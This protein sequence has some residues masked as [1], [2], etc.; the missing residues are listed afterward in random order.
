MMESL[1]LFLSDFLMFMPQT[2]TRLIAR[3][4]QDLW[5]WQIIALISGV[6]LLLLIWYRPAHDHLTRLDLPRS[7]LNYDRLNY[8]RLINAGLCVCWLWVGLVFHFEY[9]T[10]ITWVAWGFG[11]LFVLQGGLFLCFGVVL[12]KIQYQHR[13]NRSLIHRSGLVLVLF[14]LFIWPVITALN[15]GHWLQAS[16]FGFSPDATCIGTM[17]FILLAKS[18]RVWWCLLLPVIWGFISAALVWTMARA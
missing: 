12:D 11:G 4:H 1:L 2:Y 15:T 5:P 9:F 10:T 16:T 8:D 6:L 18:R 13:H 7:R 17:G 3:Y 14:A